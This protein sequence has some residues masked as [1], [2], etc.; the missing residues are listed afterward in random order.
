MRGS[1]SAGST[2]SVPM[3]S[4]MPQRPTIERAMR[5]T[6][7]E[8]ALG[9]GRDDVEDLLLRGHAAQRADDAAAQVVRVVAVAIG[10]GRRQRHAQRAAARNDRHLAHRIGAG[11][12][13]AEQRVTGLV[14]RRAA[15]LLLGDHHVARGAEL[16]LLERVGQV[17]LARRRPAPRRAASSAASLTRLARSAPVMPGVDAASCSRSTSVGERD[18]ARVDLQDLDAALV[19]GRVH[20]DRAGRTG[21]AAAAPGR[22]R[23]AGWWRPARPRPRGRRSRPSR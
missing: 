4:D 22:A 9:A 18:L 16:D 6:D 19:V 7:L 14:V 5:V 21:R 23:R 17:A 2:D 10:L 20:D 1:P 11:L 8:V 15:A 3:R 13:H 12:Q